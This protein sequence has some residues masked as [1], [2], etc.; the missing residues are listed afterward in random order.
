M[1][2]Q[3][4]EMIYQKMK[5]NGSKEGLEDDQAYKSPRGEVP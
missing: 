2:K 4:M 1:M 5:N 3:K